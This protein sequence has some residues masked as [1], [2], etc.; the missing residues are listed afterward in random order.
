[1][2]LELSS[3]AQIKKAVVS[4]YVQQAILVEAGLRVD[5]KA[6]RELELPEEL[7]RIL[8]RD[9]KLAKAL[10]D[11]GAATRLRPFTSPARSNHR[12]E[13]RASRSVSTK[14]SP[15]WACRTASSAA[16]VEP[17]RRSPYAAFGVVAEWGGA[18]A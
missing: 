13:P 7:T 5:F 16:G 2:R 14:S 3:E 10:A 18:G 6:K 11:A 9:R 4:S 15:A 8:Q 1:M 17:P 12:R